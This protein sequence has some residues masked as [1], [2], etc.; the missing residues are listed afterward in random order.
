MRTITTIVL[1]AAALTAC[2]S[3]P[4]PPS[5]TATNKGQ[6]T[7]EHGTGG[8][9]EL[10]MPGVTVDQAQDAIREYAKSLDG[11]AE[12]YEI[13]VI[14]DSDST[15]TGRPPL[16]YVCMGRW[17]KDK[18]ASQDWADGSITSKTWPAIGM[19]CPD[20]DSH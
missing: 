2:S 6:K 3:E 8:W 7:F 17:V 5:Y 19:H 20:H 18:Q 15:V 9:V 1:L 10:L 4:A 13:A 14:R 16:T 11:P 12:M